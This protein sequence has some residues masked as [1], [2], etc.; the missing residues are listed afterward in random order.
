MIQTQSAILW[1]VSTPTF[2]QRLP[3]SNEIKQSTKILHTFHTGKERLYNLVPK[4]NSQLYLPQST[5]DLQT[6]LLFSAGLKK[7]VK[8]RI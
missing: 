1:A 7:T 3:Y 5:T 8:I 4:T 2:H 6:P